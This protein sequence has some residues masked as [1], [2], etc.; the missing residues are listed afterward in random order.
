MT[1]LVGISVKGKAVGGVIHQP[2]YNYKIC[3]GDEQGRTLWGIIGLGT[4]GI[5]VQ[6]P[7]TNKFIVITT[8]SH[9]NSLVQSALD[10]LQ[11]D[12][13]IRVGGAGHKVINLCNFKLMA[14]YQSYEC[15]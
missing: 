9:C 12:E 2:Y 11:P 4:G 5:Q 8:R 6:P 10:A 7:P 1:V 3:K 13:I 15:W 14:H